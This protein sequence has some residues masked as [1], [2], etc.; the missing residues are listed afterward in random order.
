MANTPNI[1]LEKPI[2][3]DHALVS[4][5]NSNSDK[6]DTFAGNTNQAIGN[7][8][9]NINARALTS[10]EKLTVVALNDNYVPVNS[11]RW[12]NVRQAD[13]SDLPLYSTSSIA[14]VTKRISGTCFIQM[15]NDGGMSWTNSYDGANWSGWKENA[16][17]DDI[18]NLIK[19]GTYTG[20]TN[21]NGLIY[22]SLPSGS[23]MLNAYTSYGTT[24][25]IQFGPSGYRA[26]DL[27][28][29]AFDILR[30]TEITITFFYM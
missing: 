18:A 15:F 23:N 19:S 2:G 1:N 16:T 3:T 9:T 28:N 6:I 29:G 14:R 12:F 21:V 25:L 17:K 4:V 20:T 7:L 5:I 11:V 26:Y 27:S 13:A 22:P 10:S 8:N 24:A 30:N